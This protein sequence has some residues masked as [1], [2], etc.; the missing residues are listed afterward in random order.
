MPKV[1]NV[2]VASPGDV[3][4]ER[5]CLSQVA[6]RLN[7]QLAEHLG[8]RLELME[9]RQVAPGMGRPEDVILDQLP[10]EM[11]D[12]FI[13]LLWLRFGMPPGRNRAGVDHDSG[14]EQEF[15]LAYR[16]WPRQTGLVL[17]LNAAIAL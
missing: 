7:Y 4:K 14:T 8:V 12:V 11:W 17:S 13:G 10:V 15:R 9:W 1:I 2:F 3:A 6:E 16:G 5:Q